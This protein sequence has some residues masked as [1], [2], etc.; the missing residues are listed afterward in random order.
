MLWSGSWVKG[1]GVGQWLSFENSS[2]DLSFLLQLIEIYLCI[3]ITLLS[4]LSCLEKPHRGL[5][6][7]LCHATTFR[8]H[9]PEVELSIRITLLGCL[10][11]PV[12]RLLVVLRYSTTIPIHLGD[13]E[14]RIR[15]PLV[16]R[17][18]VP[19]KVDP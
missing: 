3:F 8:I 9:Y 5:V 11:V 13:I 2:C 7:V 15:K 18:A 14:L 4:L 12:Y 10:S 1:L 17:L 16:G 6:F 19:P